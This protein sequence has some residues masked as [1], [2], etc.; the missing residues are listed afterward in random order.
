MIRIRVTE[1]MTIRAKNK[2][3]NLG[4]LRNSIRKGGGNEAGFL[5]EEATIMAYPHAYVDNTYEH[6]IILH[7][8]KIEVK[9]KDRTV[10][11]KPNYE[12]SVSDYNTHQKADLYV[13]T[14]LLRTDDGYTDAY[15]LGYSSPYYYFRNARKIL[16]G[17]TDPTNNWT[18][19]C[20][21]YNLRI[22]KLIP[23]EMLNDFGA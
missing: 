1:E 10:V 11:P 22:S 23:P 20:D 17:E 12:C 21:C 15:I 2:A 6:D 19:S 4:E 5:G 18:A 9:S 16:R 14:S 13:F 7:G 3:E 8:Y